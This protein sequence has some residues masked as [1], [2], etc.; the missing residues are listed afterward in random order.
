MFAF[1]GKL[2]F[3]E[4]RNLHVSIIRQFSDVIKLAFKL[5]LEDNPF[6]DHSQQA[7]TYATRK[8]RDRGIVSLGSH[9]F[10]LYGESG[11]AVCCEQISIEERERILALVG[12]GEISLHKGASELGVPYTTIVS[13]IHRGATVKYAFVGPIQKRAYSNHEIGNTAW[14]VLDD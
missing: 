10:L 8:I 1:G 13:R 6:I 2:A 11:V 12:K 14:Q 3:F 9:N 7:D 4:F 5:R